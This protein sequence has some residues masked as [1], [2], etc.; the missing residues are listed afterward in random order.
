MKKYNGFIPPCGIYCGGCSRYLREK[1]PCLGAEEHCKHRKCKGIYVCCKEKK[2]HNYCYECKSFPCSRFK[3]FS[4]SWMKLGQDLILNQ[5]QL[6]ELGEKE[7]LDKWNNES[8]LN[9]H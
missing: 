8:I 4:E 6:K 3:K 2:N 7:W 1:N 9:H 5:Y